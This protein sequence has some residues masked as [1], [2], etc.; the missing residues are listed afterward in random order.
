[1]LK[2]TSLTVAKG[3]HYFTFLLIIIVSTAACTGSYNLAKANKI[4]LQKTTLHN[5]NGLYQNK[6]NNSSFYASSLYSRLI[7]YKRDSIV[8]WKNTSVEIKIEANHINFTLL[9]DTLIIKSHKLKYRYKNGCLVF[10][11]SKLQG[12]PLLFY[13]Y[14]K[15]RN[16]LAIDKQ[17]NL[18]LQVKGSSEGGFFIFIFGSPYTASYTYIRVK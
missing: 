10:K 18:T 15:T 9:S 5:L 13:R 17:H 2:Q 8:N 14:Q 3:I 7:P 12:V 11:K 6:E 16:C 1:M 4:L